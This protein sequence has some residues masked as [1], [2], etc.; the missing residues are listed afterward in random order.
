VKHKTQKIMKKKL[1]ALTLMAGISAV[2]LT[3]NTYSGSML[4][5]ET[6]DGKIIEMEMAREPVVVD[7][8]PTD[9]RPMVSKGAADIENHAY[10]QA[11]V[12]KIQKPEE[13]E[14]LPFAL[15]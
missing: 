4:V 13:A 14:A 10:F 6:I 7:D 1:F 15:D 8:I 2:A 11:L 9:I 3:A 12:K 5:F